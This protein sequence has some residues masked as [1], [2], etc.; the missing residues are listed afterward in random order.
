MSK[1]LLKFLNSIQF[2][3]AEATVAILIA[4]DENPE[5]VQKL[6]K[7]AQVYAKPFVETEL[8]DIHSKDRA[9]WKGKY[10]KEALGKINKGFKN[11]LTNKE[12]EDIMEDPANEGKTFDA[13]VDVLVAK[14]GEKSGKSDSEIKIMLDKANAENEELKGKLT[15]TEA[16]HIADFEN[17]KRTGKITAKL[18][19]TLVEYLTKKTSMNATKAAELLKD[20]LM[21][22]ALIDI[23]DKDELE[24]LDPSSTPDK[25]VL[26]KKDETTLQTLEGLVDQ[27]ATEYELP[28]I[29]SGGGKNVATGGQ[30]QQQQQ[31]QDP[32]DKFANT[33][34]PK[35]QGLAAALATASA[36]V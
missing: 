15:A 27:L 2:P 18:E 34:L 14:A 13:V 28:K 5:V 35:A 33:A 1:T 36:S 24:L 25:R 4:D 26:L 23:N 8:N 21:Q 31:K 3:D 16:K 17:F 9:T 32:T 11:L 12:I 6:L 22:R 19:K 10:F 29:E 7:Q 30:Q 20:K